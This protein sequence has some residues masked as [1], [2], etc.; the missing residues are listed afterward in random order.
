MQTVTR[1]PVGLG[2]LRKLALPKKLGL[3]EFLYGSALAT[4]EIEW[5]QCSN[6]ITWK[7]DLRDP[8][9]RWIVYGDY[10]GGIGISFAKNALK[11]GGVFVDSGSN[12][13][14]W[15]LYLGSIP[16]VRALEFEPVESQRLWLEEC[17]DRQTD[18]QCKTFPWALGAKESETE[19]QC[20]GAR[21]TL[22]PDWYKIKNLHKQSIK[23]KR[24]DDILEEEAV[25]HVELWKLDVEGAEYDALLGATG[26]LASQ[27]IKRLYFECHHSSY[28]LSKKLLFECGYRLYDLTESGL[29][30]KIDEV[31]HATQDLVALPDRDF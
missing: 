17:L 9:H 6:G 20:D 13:G 30:L 8:T 10:E 31:I 1:L 3:L 5:V 4:R 29:Q 28:L 11:D 7:L 23:I 15:L 27:R 26:Y 21:S 24:L 25:N 19:I 2:L 14:Q 22:R 18:W 16:N 12:I